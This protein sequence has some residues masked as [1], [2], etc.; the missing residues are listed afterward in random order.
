MTPPSDPRARADETLE[1]MAMYD[2]ARMPLDDP[3]L[4][5]LQRQIDALFAL[6]RTVTHQI[7]DLT[8]RAQR[9]ETEV[10]LVTR[11]VGAMQQTVEQHI[12][13]SERRETQI[14][15]RMRQFAEA[16]Q[17]TQRAISDAVPLLQEIKDAQSGR[18]W[19]GGILKGT[20]GA[21]IAVTTI[22]GGLVL[23]VR[24]ASGMSP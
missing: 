3:H 10:G 5:A 21:V 4:N 20:S 18:R 15:E 14:E 16:Q 6:A 9:Q 13:A 22:V 23:L 8:I 17:V 1:A 7:A 19:L 11:A 2:S 24:W 12:L